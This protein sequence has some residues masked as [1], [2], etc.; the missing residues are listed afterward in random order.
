MEIMFNQ[1]TIFGTG[2]FLLS[3]LTTSVLIAGLGN[4][5]SNAAP[6]ISENPKPSYAAAISLPT[7]DDGTIEAESYV[8]STASG[9]ALKE[10]RSR[11]PLP[12]ASLT[13]IMTA[14]LLKERGGEAVILISDTAKNTTPK[15]SDLPVGETITGETAR[16]LV[17]VESDND[18]AEAAAAAI[19]ALIEPD[20]NPRDA[21]IRGMNRKASRLG[22]LSTQF[23][24]P[25]GLDEQGHYSSAADLAKLLAYIDLL[26]PDFWDITA[27]PPPAVRGLSGK[28]YAVKSSSLLVSYPGLVG[29]KTGLTDEAM[30]ALAL[31]YRLTEF[32]EDIYIILLRS[33]DR[34]RDGEKLLAAVRRAF[35]AELK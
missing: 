9:V 1:R 34:F 20:V 10:R 16:I 25:T 31:K 22:M 7:I 19:G 15:E 3:M 12:I 28:T 17:L 26:H 13:K 2:V 24:N 18:V 33:P 21:F 5:L 11:K 4:N 32:P 35:Q 6:E 14:L 30:G 27:S 8:V 23:Q 29:T